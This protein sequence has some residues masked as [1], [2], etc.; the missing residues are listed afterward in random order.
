MKNIISSAKANWR[1]TLGGILSI[2]SVVGTYW[3][4][5]IAEPV[6]QAVGILAGLGLIASKDPK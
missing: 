2:L 6:S 4:P 1:T 5:G 3:L